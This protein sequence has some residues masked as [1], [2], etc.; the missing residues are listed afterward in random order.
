VQNSIA[1]EFTDKLVKKVS[2]LKMG[3]GLDST[4]TQGPLVN[5]AAV[6]KVQEHVDDAVAK[7][8]KI[9]FGGKPPAGEGFHFTPT[10]ISNASPDMNVASEETFGPLAPIFAFEKE[11]DAIRLSNDTEFGLAGY[12]FS[13]DISRCMRVAAKLQVGMVGV[14]TGKISAAEAPFGGVKESGYG[15]EGSLYGLEE[16]QVIKS[17]TIGNQ[18]H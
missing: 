13:R 18:Q 8:G 1:A 10:V 11:E 17:I 15:R 3:P 12:F 6:A 14:N 5:A 2:K 7:G 9:E 16:Y 4:T